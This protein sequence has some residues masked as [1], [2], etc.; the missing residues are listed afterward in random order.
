MLCCVV[1]V[2][3]V[4]RER[5]RENKN[6]KTKKKFKKKQL[7]KKN[8]KRTVTTSHA[9]S[10]LMAGSSSTAEPASSHAEHAGAR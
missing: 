7:E 2:V 5:E 4:Q 3:L 10:L 8:S 9:P 1:V 6:P